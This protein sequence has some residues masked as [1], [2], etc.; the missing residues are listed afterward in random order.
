MKLIL[1]T[2]CHTVA[3]GHAYSTWNEMV[4]SASDKGLELI[5]ITDHAPAMPGSTHI[6]YF[7]NQRILPSHMYGVEVLKGVEVNI[8]D[9]DGGLDLDN[10]TLSELDIVIASLHPPCIEGGTSEQ[11]TNAVIQVMKN[12]NVHIIGHPDD[13]RFNLDYEA[14]VLTAK[15]QNILLEVN[16]ASLD[17]KGFRK[18]SKE[19]AKKIL[20]LC[21][22]YKTP[23]VLGSDAHFLDHVA[24]FSNA[25]SLIKEVDF[26]ENLIVNQSVEQLKSY[27]K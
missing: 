10:D 22:E 3:S 15:E 26:P 19:N 18:N 11:Y 21:K 16:N 2:H 20:K 9:F 25:V 7:H 8:I 17:P 23:V 24:N 5:A 1:D 27:L 13:G 4:K 6:F 14:I 12:P